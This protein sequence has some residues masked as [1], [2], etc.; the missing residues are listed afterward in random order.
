ME[1]VLCFSLNSWNSFFGQLYNNGSWHIFLLF[2]Q[3]LIHITC[4]RCLWIW[5]RHFQHPSAHMFRYYVGMVLI[6]FR[7]EIRMQDHCSIPFRT[8]SLSFP[9]IYCEF[10]E[11]ATFFVSLNLLIFMFP[12][13]FVA[14]NLYTDKRSMKNHRTT[15]SQSTRNGKFRL[16]F[17]SIE[18]NNW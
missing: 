4:G 7:F 9:Q 12:I 1:L 11:I 6:Y 3:S 5:K 15:E 18:N 8:Y 13:I 10:E 14:R 17:A 16:C 2:N